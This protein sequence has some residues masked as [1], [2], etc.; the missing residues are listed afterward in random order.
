MNPI[1]S[2]VAA[3]CAA[4]CL[5]CQQTLTAHPQNT[6]TGGNGNFS[7]FGVFSTGNGAEGHTQFLVPAQELPAIGA[8]LVGIE[9]AALVP[10]TVDY[11]SLQISAS[12]T[13]A[14]SLSMTFASNVVNPATV[15]LP[16]GPLQATFSTSAWTRIDFPTPYGHDGTSALVLDIQ[17]VAQP[18]GGSFQFVTHLKNALPPRTDRPQMVYAFSNPGGGGSTATT[19]FANDEPISFRLVWLGTPTLRNQSDAGMFGGLQYAVG[20]TVTLTTQGSPG[21]LWALAAGAA[22]FTPGIPVPGITGEFRL[23]GPVVFAAGLLDV[24]GLGSTGIAIPNNPMLVGLYLAYQGGT[25]D[26]S[27]GQIV[28]TNGTDHFVNM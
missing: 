26:P 15:V 22:F 11:A 4:V 1:S 6:L 2:A 10:G 14:T 9:L 16:A 8:V 12:P 17:K 25:I 3:L 23:N 24:Q 5:P 7:P 21:F 27:T 13:T 20:T 19:A 28:L 18:I